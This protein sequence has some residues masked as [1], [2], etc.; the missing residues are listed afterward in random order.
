MRGVPC[1]PR[2]KLGRAAAGG[3]ERAS[4]TRQRASGLGMAAQREAIDDYPSNGVATMIA[5]FTRNAN[6]PRRAPHLSR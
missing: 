5:R 4:T 2:I 3:L 1:W 6:P